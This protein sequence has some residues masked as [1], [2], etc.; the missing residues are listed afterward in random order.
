MK[1][2]LLKGNAV[3]DDVD[4]IRGIAVKIDDLILNHLRIGDDA[5][6]AAICEQSLFELQSIAMLWIKPSNKA[7]ERQ[8]KFSPAS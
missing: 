2:K 1:T 5:A 7:F 4:F 3:A 6:G 8:F